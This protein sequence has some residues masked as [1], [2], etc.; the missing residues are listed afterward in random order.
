MK[1]DRYTSKELGV[2]CTDCI[3]GK[4][5]NINPRFKL[6]SIDISENVILQF[7]EFN[8]GSGYRAFR[9]P[10]NIINN[11]KINKSILYQDRG[12]FKVL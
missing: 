3:V 10:S 8:K 4:P 6:I 9:I 12:V 11:Y 7:E 1:T 2:W 5:E